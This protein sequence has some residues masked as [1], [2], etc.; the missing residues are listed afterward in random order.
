MNFLISSYIKIDS[1]KGKAGNHHMNLLN[2]KRFYFYALIKP[3]E[4]IY[5]K[6]G[7]TLM[8]TCLNLY[9]D[10]VCSLELQPDMF[11]K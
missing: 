3:I 8:G 11:Q 2:L 1:E 7:L 10:L 6:Y 9:R 5:R 4:K